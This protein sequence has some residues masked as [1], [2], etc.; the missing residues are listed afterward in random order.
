M[1]QNTKNSQ[2]GKSHPTTQTADRGQTSDK[3]NPKKNSSTSP[4]GAQ[5]HSEK[6]ITP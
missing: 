5:K 2:G 6:K 4:T 1:P 3:A